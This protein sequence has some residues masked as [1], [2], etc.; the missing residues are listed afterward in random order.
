MAAAAELQKGLFAALAAD[1]A[2]LV[3]L[4]GPNVF[5]HP[6]DH[7]PF[8]CITFGRTSVY[9]WSTATEAGSEHFVTLNVWSKATGRKEALAVIDAVQA[10]LLSAPPLLESHHLVNL[11]L[12]NVEVIHD[13]AL[14]LHHGSLR[15]RAVIEH[16]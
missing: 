14:A 11:T 12:E 10:C 16:H 5:D 13:E 7:A 4:G 15:L 8:P 3:Q 1:A 9:D 6:P 2:L